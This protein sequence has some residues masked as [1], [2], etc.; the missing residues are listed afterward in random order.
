M[1]R[2]Y[3]FNAEVIFVLVQNWESRLSLS[4]V[5]WA[6]LKLLDDYDDDNLDVGA[7]WVV[8]TCSILAVLRRFVED[9]MF[10]WN[11]GMEWKYYTAQK[12]RSPPF[13]AVHIAFKTSNPTWTQSP[14][15]ALCPSV[16]ALSTSSR[17]LK[18]FP[19]SESEPAIPT[20]SW[21]LRNPLEPYGYKQ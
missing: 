15:F 12:S 2:V 20:C 8:A 10:L 13:A 17:R 9:S 3:G 6:F 7:L 14:P 5:F 1:S 21:S 11:V 4:P 19:L 18:I 16:P